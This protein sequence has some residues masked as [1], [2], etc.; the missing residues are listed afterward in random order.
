MPQTQ[1]ISSSA[2]D[3]AYTAI[4]GCTVQ[5]LS[6]HDAEARL[7]EEGF[8][9]LPSSRRRNIFAIAF[10]VVRGDTL[11]LKEGDRVPADALVRSAVNLTVDES[12]LTGESVPVRK[13]AVAGSVPM[14]R[15]G[16]DDLPSVYSSTL[17]VQGH[18]IAEVQGIGLNTEIGKIGKALQSVDSEA[19]YLSKETGRLVRNLTMVGLTLCA[20]VVTIYGITRGDWLQGFLAGITLAMATLPEEI[21]VVLTVFLALGAW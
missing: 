5:G 12:L 13:S 15:P 20:L 14:D 19:T 4:D 7:R 2:K 1:D 16:G 8:N 18:G 6:S 9:E 3:Q 10:D 11:I 17:V 21:P